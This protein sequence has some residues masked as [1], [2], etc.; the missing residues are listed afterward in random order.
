MKTNIQILVFAFLVFSF[1]CNRVDSLI[2][3]KDWTF[4]DPI[5]DIPT[6]RHYI[7]DQISKD[8]LS[9]GDGKYI[10]AYKEVEIDGEQNM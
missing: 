3:L 6:E 7:G 4:P 8:Q 10:L 9:Y 2:D 1:N 5:V